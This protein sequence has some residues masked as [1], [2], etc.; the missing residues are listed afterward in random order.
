MIFWK[1]KLYIKNP[2]TVDYKKD[3]WF[4]IEALKSTAI[5]TNINCEC[6]SWMISWNPRDPGEK[7]LILDRKIYLDIFSNKS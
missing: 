1:N 5:L 4:C 7:L 2:H 6:G 3:P